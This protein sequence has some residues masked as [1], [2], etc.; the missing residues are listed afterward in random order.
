VDP[1]PK[2]EKIYE[3]KKKKTAKQEQ[4][5]KANGNVAGDEV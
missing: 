4:I 3:H 1:V 2:P 5:E